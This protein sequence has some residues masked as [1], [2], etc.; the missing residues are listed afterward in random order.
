MRASIHAS[1]SARTYAT[2][3]SP[4]LTAFGNWPSSAIKLKSGRE[5][6]VARAASLGAIK[7]GVLSFEWSIVL[8]Y[9][10]ADKRGN[11]ARQSARPKANNNDEGLG[12]PLI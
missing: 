5:R 1:T 9:S 8:P 12:P 11:C 3:R 10:N 6:L 7:R 2:R 4:S